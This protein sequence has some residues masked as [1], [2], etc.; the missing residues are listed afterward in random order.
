[1]GDESCEPV[2]LQY[3]TIGDTLIYGVRDNLVRASWLEPGVVITKFYL[4]LDQANRPC[5]AFSTF[6]YQPVE[7]TDSA[8]SMENL[9]DWIELCAKNHTCSSSD[10]PVLPTRVV[11][12]TVRS[13]I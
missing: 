11:E 10:D 12:V 9:K 6:K 4:F 2:H 1:M 3:R 7:R 8:R 5:R 13:I